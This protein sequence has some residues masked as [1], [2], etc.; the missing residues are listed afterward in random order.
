MPPQMPPLRQKLG[1]FLSFGR[2][3]KSDENNYQVAG[4]FSGSTMIPT[5]SGAPRNAAAVD[6][7][8]TKANHCST[9][10]PGT[11]SLEV[12]VGHPEDEEP[13]QR[14]AAIRPKPAQARGAHDCATVGDP[15]SVHDSDAVSYLKWMLLT[16]LR[17]DKLMLFEALTRKHVSVS[18]MVQELPA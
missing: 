17:R 12:L 11:A 6:V 5:E 18:F 13:L 9:G 7:A 8:G 16:T 1:A 4:D 14:G 10:L 15:T 2:K 3:K